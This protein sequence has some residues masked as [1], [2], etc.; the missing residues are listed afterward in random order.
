MEPSMCSRYLLFSLRII[1]EVSQTMPEAT[2]RWPETQIDFVDYPEM[3]NLRHSLLKKRLC[4]VDGPNISMA[5]SNDENV[6]NAY[7]S[8]WTCMHYCSSVLALSPDWCLFFSLNA[9]GSW[10]DAAVARLY[11]KL[12]RRTHE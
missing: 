2:I 8:E 10:H 4:F 11:D 3:I 6:Q 9:L 12:M 1:V 7:Y 5:T